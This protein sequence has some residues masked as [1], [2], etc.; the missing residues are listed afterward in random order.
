MSE[1][2]GNVMDFENPCEFTGCKVGGTT[3]LCWFSTGHIR[4]RSKAGTFRSWAGN[5]MYLF[6]SGSCPFRWRHYLQTNGKER[7]TLKHLKLDKQFFLELCNGAVNKK[8]LM[9]H[10]HTCIFQQQ[11][12]LAHTG[13]FNQPLII[14]Y[15][16]E[17]SLKDFLVHA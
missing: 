4:S 13:I 14:S 3:G 15:K 5:Y 10:W 7:R 6:R 17:K 9:K 16:K 8:F 2:G 11:P 1:A 12:R